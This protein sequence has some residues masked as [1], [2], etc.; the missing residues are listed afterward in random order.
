MQSAECGIPRRELARLKSQAFFNSA[1]AL[2][3][4]HFQADE[5][6]LAYCSRQYHRCLERDR[7]SMG[8]ALALAIE[9]THDRR[10]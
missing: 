5:V 2:R 4:P 9:V 7:L 10:Q 1:F 3:I 6:E 8:R